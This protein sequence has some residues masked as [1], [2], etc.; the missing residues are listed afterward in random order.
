MQVESQEPKQQDQQY[1]QPEVP[2]MQV[3]SSQ[4]WESRV[5]PK[6]E[7]LSNPAE[8]LHLDGRAAAANILK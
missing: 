7:M 1:K 5:Y 3:C 8:Q 4:F 2:G 6:M